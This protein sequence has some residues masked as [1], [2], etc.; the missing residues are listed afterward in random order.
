MAARYAPEGGLVPQ[1]VSAELIADKWGL[2]REEL[3]AYG[4]RSQELARRARDE[5][6]FD[7][8]ILPVVDDT[9]AT[10]ATATTRKPI[11]AP[12]ASAG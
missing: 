2:T 4:L 5:G 8:Q 11:A 10:V 12:A 6:R 9:G 7:A 3:D 1:G